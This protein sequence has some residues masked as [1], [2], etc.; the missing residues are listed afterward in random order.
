MTG[1]SE[2]DVVTKLSPLPVAA[3]VERLTGLISAKGMRLF[4]VIDQRAE[5]RKAGLDLR[6]T[7]LVIFGSPAAGTPVMDASPL[8]ALDLPLKVLIWDDNGQAKVTYYAPDAIAARH[9]VPAGLAA[10]LAGVN[11]LTD[12]LIS[13]GPAA[14]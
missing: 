12:A 8:A 14:P 6:D 2:P 5:A 7:V 4:A 3:T 10:N 11:A 1:I 9:H 13:G